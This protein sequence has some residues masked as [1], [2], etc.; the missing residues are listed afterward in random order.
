MVH[1]W[2]ICGLCILGALCPI[3]SVPHALRAESPLTDSVIGRW[4]LLSLYD[5]DGT[6]QDVTWFGHNPDGSLILDP[7]GHFSLQI[8]EGRHALGA[9]RDG[10]ITVVGIVAARARTLAYSGRYYLEGHTIHFQIEHGLAPF[11]PASDV[12][13]VGDRMDFISSMELSPTGSDYSHLVW[14]RQP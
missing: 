6:G 2:Q 1:R 13:V 10:S 7:G 11:A 3:V 5:E 12:R 9:V 8:D 4:K 14:E